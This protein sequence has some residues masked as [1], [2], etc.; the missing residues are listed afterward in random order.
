MQVERID[1]GQVRALG[2]AG[3]AACVRSL[4]AGVQS[5]EAPVREILA[6]VRAEGDAAVLRLTGELDLGGGEPMPLL[7]SEAE[8]DSAIVSMPRES[9]APSWRPR[10]GG[11][12]RPR[13]SFRCVRTL[14][15]SP[16][17]IE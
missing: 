14:R 4:V 1:L 9:R 8:L 16:S 17:A 7:V 6:A 5:V 15:D 3:V 12:P 11:L 10:M 2:A 13:S